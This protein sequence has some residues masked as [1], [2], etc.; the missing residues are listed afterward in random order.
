MNT[1]VNS[2]AGFAV[3]FALVFIIVRFIYYPQRRDKSYI[4]TFFTFNTVI[5]FV[6]GLLNDSGLSVGVGFGLFAIFSILRYRTDTI[7][8]REMTYLFVLIALPVMNSILLTKAAYTEFAAINLVTIVVLY[9]LEQGWGFN[10]ESSKAI[11]YERIDLIRPENWPVLLADLRERT[12]LPVKR[13][14]IGRLNF[15]RDTAE[16]VVYYDPDALHS[17]Q[18]KFTTNTA[19]FVNHNDSDD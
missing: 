17:E 19:S 11:T 13:I 8:I 18:V 3:N 5:F 14:E 1:F 16:I 2:L 9:V 6:M 12:G 10:Y 4:F 15:L 7:P